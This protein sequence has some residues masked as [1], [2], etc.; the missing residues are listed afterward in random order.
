MILKKVNNFFYACKFIF[1]K[2]KKINILLLLLII[3]LLLF[4]TI[5]FKIKI[6][7]IEKSN[8]QEAVSEKIVIDKEE[9][10][11][12]IFNILNEYEKIIQTVNIYA[13]SSLYVSSSSDP[14]FKQINDLKNRVVGIK[15]P[16]TKYKDLHLNLLMSLLALKEYLEVPV[17]DKG[18]VCIDYIEK[19]KKSRELLLD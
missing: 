5:L 14:I 12:N 4:L 6:T 10:R 1:L 3:L 8:P 9:Y 2:H 11:K 18:A 13:S 17:K 19:V 15:A 16:E 7:S